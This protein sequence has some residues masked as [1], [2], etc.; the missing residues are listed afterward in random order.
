MGKKIADALMV[1]LYGMITAGTI[2][3]TSCFF[4]GFC[5]LGLDCLN[6]KPQ[7]CQQYNCLAFPIEWADRYVLKTEAFENG[8]FPMTTLIFDLAIGA[9]LGA[10][11]GLAAEAADSSSGNSNS[12]GGAITHYQPSEFENLIQKYNEEE[13]S[14]NVERNQLE[15]ELKESIQNLQKYQEDAQKDI[16]EETVWE[17]EM[18]KIL[19]KYL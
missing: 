15:R 18:D 9:V 4:S 5:V 14:Q 6:E 16:Q 17:S 3:L 19:K 11:V 8:D 7:D 1:A 12:S 13:E 10:L 2:W